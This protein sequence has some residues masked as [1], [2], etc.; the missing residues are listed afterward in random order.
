MKLPQDIKN[1][2]RLIAAADNLI[3]AARRHLLWPS[4]SSK[5]DL[6]RRVSWYSDARGEV[7][8]AE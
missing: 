7:A 2:H 4:R 6:Q 8:A 5:D 1:A 3:Y